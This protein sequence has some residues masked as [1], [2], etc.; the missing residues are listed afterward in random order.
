MSSF[1]VEFEARKAEALRLFSQTPL[2]AEKF[3]PAVLRLAWRAGIRIPPPHFAGFMSTAVAAGAGF[4]VFFTAVMWVLVWR[5]A[6]R[7]S[8]ESAAGIGVAA[9]VAGVSIAGAYAV[10]RRKFGL[11]LWRDL[12][13]EVGS[14]RSKSTA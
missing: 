5:L 4:G 12:R 10:Q 11:P 2:R 14:P 13:I 3:A 8:P 1:P 9:A 7:S 6:P